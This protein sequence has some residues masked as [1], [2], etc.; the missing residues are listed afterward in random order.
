MNNTS[1]RFHISSTA[2]RIDTCNK[3]GLFG[4]TFGFVQTSQIM[5]E[6]RRKYYSAYKKR[7]KGKTY[8]PDC[9]TV[10]LMLDLV[11][12]LGE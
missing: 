7:K 4:Y 6:K 8:I 11:L 12:I 9:H 3:G 10:K 1:Q 5:Q 2:R